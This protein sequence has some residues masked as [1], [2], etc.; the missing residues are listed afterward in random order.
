MPGGLSVASSDVDLV[1]ILEFSDSPAYDEYVYVVNL[2]ES[3]AEI[4]DLS[5]DG[6]SCYWFQWDSIPFQQMPADDPL[7][8]PKVLQEGLKVTGTFS[9]GS[10]NEKTLKSYRVNSVPH[11]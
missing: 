3:S 1:A 2:N 9:F 4:N 8:Y 7:W 11:L 6:N 10:W 5:F